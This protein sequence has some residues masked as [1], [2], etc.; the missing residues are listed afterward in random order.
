M[1]IA[2]IKRA[3]AKEAADILG[4]PAHLISRLDLEGR[5]IKRFKLT[6]R[7]HVFD[8]QSLYA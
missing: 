7:T 1:R 6:R 3:T 2:S 4:M 5:W 8:I